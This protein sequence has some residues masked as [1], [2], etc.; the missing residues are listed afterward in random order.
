MSLVIPVP[1]RRKAYV[2]GATAWLDALPALVADLESEWSIRI[3]AT[4]PDATEAFVASAVLADGTPAVLKLMVPRSGEAAAHEITVLRLADGGG[5]ARLLRSDAS[6]GALLLEALGRSLNDLGL[7][8]VRRLEILSDAAREVWRP[9]PD[10]GLPTGADKGE[11][12][13]SFIETTWV[14]LGH[15]LLTAR[16]RP[17][18]R[19]RVTADRRSLC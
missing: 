16:G 7:P 5:C 12:L 15:P 11:W 14:S 19:L 13:I 9:A 4:F 10:S 3:G 2:A 1:V 17:R 18:P 8:L 6:R